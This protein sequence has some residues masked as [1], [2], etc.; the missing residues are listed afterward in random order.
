MKKN[1]KALL[2]LILC[3]AL[4]FGCAPAAGAA[5]APLK[6]GDPDNDYQITIMDATR[7]QRYLAGFHR[8]DQWYTDALYEALCDADGDG[9]VTILDATNIQR[10]LAGLPCR[11]VE[12]DIWDYYV[13]DSAHHSTAVIASDTYSPSEIA[14]VGVPVTFTAQ[15]TWGAKPRSL[16]VSVDGVPAEQ[17]EVSG[18]KPFS[19]TC[20]FDTEGEHEVLMSI[21]CQYGASATRLHRVTVKALPEDG[22]PVIMGADFFDQTRMMSGDGWLTV[23]AAGGTGPYVYSYELYMEM[24]AATGADGDLTDPTEMPPDEPQPYGGYVSIDYTEE[25]AINVFDALGMAGFSPGGYG[26]PDIRVKITVRDAAGRESA[27][28]T[29]CYSYYALVA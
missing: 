16:R 10:Y 29:V 8:P 15:V 11:F 9:S 26:T 12:K 24:R 21:E 4:L 1:V 3:A 25:N 22:A 13:G 2:S 19:Y 28:V 23:T 14:Y 6:V 18:F 7:I 5:L 27:P 20:T 17:R